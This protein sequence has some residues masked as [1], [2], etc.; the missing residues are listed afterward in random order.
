MRLIPDT[1]IGKVFLIVMIAI[2]L[3]GW[4]IGSYT[5]AKDARRYRDKDD[6]GR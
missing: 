4:V 3:S 6:Q 2:A 5:G 1:G